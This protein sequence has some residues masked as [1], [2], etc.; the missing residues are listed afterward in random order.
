MKTLK[1]VAVILV[2]IVI[3]AQV[4]VTRAVITNYLNGGLL[5]YYSLDQ[6]DLKTSSVIADKSGQDHNGTITAGAGGF[7][8]NRFGQANK[9]HSFD[10]LDTTIITNWTTTAEF[11]NG[12]TISVWLRPVNAGEGSDGRVIDKS[13]G[14]TGQNGFY[15]STGNSLNTPRPR[16]QV[17]G[18]T[19]R[20]SGSILALSTWSYVTATIAS[21]ATVTIYI[22]GVQ[23]GTPGITGALSGITT[24]NPVTI[25]NR[26]GATDRTFNGRIDELKVFNKVLTARQIKGMYQQGSSAIKLGTKNSKLVAFYPLSSD[27]AQSAKRLTD[28]TNGYPVT[29]ANDIVWTTNK[30][31]E[32][33]KAIICNGAT[34]Q[35]TGVAPN[36]NA[37]SLSVWVKGNSSG[38]FPMGTMELSNA[39]SQRRGFQFAAGNSGLNIFYGANVYRVANSG[40]AYANNTWHHIAITYA[41]SGIP[42][43]YVDNVLATLGNEGAAT[44]PTGASIMKICNSTISISRI[45]KGSVAMVKWFSS[46]ISQSEIAELYKEGKN[47]V[48]KLTDGNLLGSYSLAAKD[49]LTATRISDTS[50]NGHHGSITAGASAGFTED[51]WGRPNMAYDFD[52]ADTKI[53]TGSEW[54][55]TSAITASAWIYLDG[56]GENN[57]GRIFTNGSAMWRV[58]GANSYLQFTS[59][60]GTQANSANNSITTNVWIFVAVTRTAAG[61]A[62]FYVNGILS[63]TANQA[64]DAPGAGTTNVIIGSN[65]NQTATFDGRISNV[66]VWDRVLSDDE[67]MAEYQK[68]W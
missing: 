57:L 48:M 39:S 56:Y 40:T 66:K 28:V 16:I 22:N 21:N 10:A 42:I 17:N 68:N 53:D 51:G 3:L 5:A 60:N 27:T 55:G 23:D 30:Y 47:A 6:K 12:F 41:G 46:A 43:V 59:N 67:I 63:G 13:T 14:T 62:N 26:S 49:L 36:L 20:T 7:S 44:A 2:L 32:Q 45:F 11:E 18:G 58:N 35:F 4:P 24:L 61:A 54:I 19:V 50:G 8:S 29:G 64:S 25:G 15:L 37:Y 9:A 1:A 31:G 33:N 65:S 52:G 34:D 38:T